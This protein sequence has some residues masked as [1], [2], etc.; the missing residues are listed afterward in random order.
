MKEGERVESAKLSLKG[1]AADL[2][3]DEGQLSR[4]LNPGHGKEKSDETYKRLTQRLTKNLEA[5]EG[6]KRHTLTMTL[7]GVIGALLLALI[8]QFFFKT[9]PPPETKAKVFTESELKA[10]LEIYHG[11]IEQSLITQ[12]V[13]FNAELKEGVLDETDEETQIRSLRENI[14][15]IILKARDHVKAMNLQT[16]QGV[17]LSAFFKRNENNQI[18]KNLADLLPLLLNESTP[19]TSIIQAI[20]RKT[21]YVQQSNRTVFDS[22]AD[23][24]QIE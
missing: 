4:I 3:Y 14:E 11:Y 9:S 20:L 7:V 17:E 2:G 1:I 12:G 22:I 18:D 16:P 10:F 8:S 24:V 6:K 19:T 23:P 21:D 5:E 13:N 15:T